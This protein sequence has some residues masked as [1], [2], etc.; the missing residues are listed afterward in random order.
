M[1]DTNEDKIVVSGKR[2]KTIMEGNCDR[3]CFLFKFIILL[4]LGKQRKGE[5]D[6]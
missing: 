4:S 3:I 5:R 2:H 6:L 1:R